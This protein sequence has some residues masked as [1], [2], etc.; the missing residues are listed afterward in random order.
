MEPPLKLYGVAH[1]PWTQL[2]ALACHLK[3]RPIVNVQ[4][5]PLST[6]LVHGLTIPVLWT[7]S[8]V[9]RGSDE[10]VCHLD[11]QYPLLA[12]L[13][14]AAVYAEPQW[15]ARAEE[16]FLAYAAGRIAHGPLHFLRAW[17]HIGAG[18]PTLHACVQSALR[19]LL[20]LYFCA[21]LGFAVAV[22]RMRLNE[23]LLRRNLAW[24][25]SRL[26]ESGGPYLRGARLSVADLL[27]YAHLQTIASGV[28]STARVALAVFHDEQPTLVRWARLVSTE[29]LR[30]YGGWDFAA[31]WLAA[32]DADE[33]RDSAAAA[34]AA[35][36]GRRMP[37]PPRCEECPGASRLERAVFTASLAG[38]LT[39]WLPLTLGVLAYAFLVRNFNPHRSLKGYERQLG[40][41][42]WG[43]LRHHRQPGRALSVVDP[44][45][46]STLTSGV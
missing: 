2:V 43:R 36:T 26:H 7:D 35:A 33:R 28:G 21:L 40:A 14:A 32:C 45:A 42:W 37:P 18:G 8:G 16:L 20:A 11:T 29:H 25:A 4:A 10:A 46:R 3:R 44:L 19:P 34:A 6:L 22:P 39:A 24:W 9:L 38:C 41:W 27:L 31:G 1:S 15:V 12:P 5:P 30:D 17:A 13:D 23:P